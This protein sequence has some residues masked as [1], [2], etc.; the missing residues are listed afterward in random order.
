MRGACH[1]RGARRLTSGGVLDSTLS[2]ARVV[3]GGLPSRG[4]MY[5]TCTRLDRVEAGSEAGDRGRPEFRPVCGSALR[6]TYYRMRNKMEIDTV[7]SLF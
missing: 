1:V 2:T 7:V 6:L 5:E 4:S 3:N